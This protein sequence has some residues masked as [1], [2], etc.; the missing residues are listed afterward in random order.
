MPIP[1]LR[2]DG[3]LPI[4]IHV[5][6]IN[7]IKDCFGSANKMRIK[8]LNG[9]IAA[10]K[11]MKRAGVKKVW[12][13]GSFVTDKEEPRDIDGCWEYHKG[14]DLMILDPLFLDDPKLIKL[15]YGLH[16]FVTGLYKKH[17]WP[18]TF[19]QSASGFEKKGILLINLS[20]EA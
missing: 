9:L 13:N 7:E 11:N 1:K 3:K 15:K 17:D 12:I 4:G 19:F 6:T 20:L 5:T 16:F 18:L 14:V 2:I 8:L 10:L